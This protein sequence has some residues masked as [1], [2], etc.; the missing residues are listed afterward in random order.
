M[1]ST[2]SLKRR[3]PWAETPTAI[4]NGLEERQIIANRLDGHGDALGSPGSIR[5]VQQRQCALGVATRRTRFEAHAGVV[6]GERH[7]SQLVHQLHWR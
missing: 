3:A 4:L 2:I 1:P 5:L 7:R 6:I